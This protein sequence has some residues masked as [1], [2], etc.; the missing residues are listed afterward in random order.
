ML[1]KISIENEE[2]SVGFLSNLVTIFLR[3][4]P[5]SL[6]ELL[7]ARLIVGLSALKLKCISPSQS[8]SSRSSFST[9]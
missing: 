9:E 7:A 3:V 2:G 1:P 8:L 6:G 5:P 4:E